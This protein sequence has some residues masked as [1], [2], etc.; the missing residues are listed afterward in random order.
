VRIGTPF[1]SVKVS[2]SGCGN[3]DLSLRMYTVLERIF[4]RIA[5]EPSGGEPQSPSWHRELL[6]TMVRPRAGKHRPRRLRD[7]IDD[8]AL[9][10]V[11]SLKIEPRLSHPFLQTH[12]PLY[13]HQQVQT[14][15]G[16]SQ[17]LEIEY[18]HKTSMLD[19]AIWC[20][21]NSNVARQ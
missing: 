3:D 8:D 14:A 16:C 10:R 9:K 12:M 13:F 20:S 11:K 2:Y 5:E 15:I 21:M 17:G 6:D 7:Q 4:Q 18:R 19:S 1:P